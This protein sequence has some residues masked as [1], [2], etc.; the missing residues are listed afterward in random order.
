F[1]RLRDVHLRTLFADDPKRGERLT[2][3]ARGLY[4][5]EA[6]HRVT[7]EKSRHAAQADGPGRGPGRAAARCQEGGRPAALSVLMRCGNRR[8][9]ATAALPRSLTFWAAGTN[10]ANFRDSHDALAM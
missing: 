4:L 7:D 2:A 10:R 8:P 9:S 5:D 1:P 3:E 6:K